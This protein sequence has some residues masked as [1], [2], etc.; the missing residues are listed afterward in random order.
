MANEFETALKDTVKKVAQYV[1]DAA[2]LTIETQYVEIGSDGAANFEAA[3]PVARTVIKL[4][5]DSAATLPMHRNE[6]GVLEVD[7]ALFELHQENV[8][9]AIEYRARILNALTG[10]LLNSLK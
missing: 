4:D 8:A 10:A 3:K 1:D 9:T 5:G 7:E 6:A 2:T